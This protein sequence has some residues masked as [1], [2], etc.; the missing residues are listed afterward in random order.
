L[1]GGEIL[2]DP[3][4]SK[5]SGAIHVGNCPCEEKGRI[6]EKVG[7]KKLDFDSELFESP[8]F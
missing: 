7:N 1:E 3:R 8:G 5:K 6:I 2:E 4:D